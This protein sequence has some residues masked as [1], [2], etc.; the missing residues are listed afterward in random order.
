MTH[1]SLHKPEWL[2]SLQ[3]LSHTT[4]CLLTLLYSLLKCET[5]TVA[6]KLFDQETSAVLYE[7]L[8]PTNKIHDHVV[9]I[10]LYLF[11]IY[12]LEHL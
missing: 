4:C 3:H 6:D 9:C 12:T 7:S 10:L 5:I 1:R 8:V 2:W 11:T